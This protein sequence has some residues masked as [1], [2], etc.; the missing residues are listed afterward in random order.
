MTTKP[1]KSEYVVVLWFEN[2][3]DLEWEECTPARPSAV[4]AL[5]DAALILPGRPD[6][7]HG[8]LCRTDT[9]PDVIFDRYL[10]INIRAKRGAEHGN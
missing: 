5:A 9:Y 10:N 2:G 4:E 6:L 1:I 3:P 8:E 7:N